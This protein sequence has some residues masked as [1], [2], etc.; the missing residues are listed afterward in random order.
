VIAYVVT[1]PGSHLKAE[2]V[3][4]HCGRYLAPFKTP[5]D[6]CF[7]D[8]LPKNARGKL[9]RRMLAAAWGPPTD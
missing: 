6:V 1:Q 7:V 5:K 8:E 3:I 2:D 4:A 9:D